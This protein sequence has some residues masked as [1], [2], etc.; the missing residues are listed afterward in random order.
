MKFLCFILTLL[1][2]IVPLNTA[3]AMDHGDFAALPVLHDGRVKPMDSFARIHLKIFAGRDSLP[4]L[5]AL[6]WLAETLF[7][8]AAAAERPVFYVAKPE[9]LSLPSRKGRLYSFA[10]IAAALK[11]R[12]AAIAT[13]VE[14]D[15]KTWSDDQRALMDLQSRTLLYVQLLRSFSNILPLS[16]ALPDPLLTAWKIDPAK[17][18]RTLEEFTPYEAQLQNEIRK[19]VRRK[20][21]NIETYSPAEK[22]IAL[23]AW[24]IQML[25]QGGANNMLLRIMPPQWGGNEWL[26]PWMIVQTG[27]GAPA[28][29]AYLA[30]W[31][32]MAA[33]WQAAD[34]TAWENSARAAREAVA[35]NTPRLLPLERLYNALH[36]MGLAMVCYLAAFM[37][38]IIASFRWRT[39]L[40]KAA[41]ITIIAGAILHGA[42]II[43]RIA[44]L[45]RPPVGTLYE[46]IL[47]VSLICVIVAL[48]AERRMKDGTGLMIAALSGGGLLFVAG[49][50]SPADSLEVLT[51]VLNTN[52]WLATHVLCITIGYGWC[53]VA[54][55]MAHVYLFRSAQGLAA[56]ALERIIKTCALAA[57]LFTAVGTIL[58]GIWADQ[59]W[60]RFWGWDPKENGALLIVL[61]LIWL[62]HARLAG[63]LT[64]LPFMA[65]MAALT[66]IVA[67]AWFGVN[68]LSTGLHSYGFIEGV[69]G[70]LFAFCAA[71]IALI[72]ALWHKARAREITA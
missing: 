49:A 34:E 53:A 3:R 21:E 71:E 29:A 8:P 5:G 67:I 30:Q 47:F 48:M 17:A 44:I 22:D 51:A 69:A 59:S 40:I 65:G 72:A 58:G 56:D 10:E 2:L 7:N 38:V 46:S 55:I 70:G 19:I 27:L 23:L 32:S 39:P 57:L 37:A 11:P 6:D 41:S 45:G 43:A 54:G 28:A 24:Q 66:I 12:E 42:S 25:Q 4:G 35:D 62:L 63:Q 18:P 60:G 1:C 13:L 15:E 14:K 16:I 9:G 31:K 26:S 36:P 33:A 68:L 50:F 64:R 61:W 20:G 52:F